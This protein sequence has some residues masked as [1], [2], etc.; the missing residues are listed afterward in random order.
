MQPFSILSLVRRAPHP[1]LVVC[2]LACTTPPAASPARPALSEPAATGSS[3]PTNERPASS[4][5]GDVATAPASGDT[6]PSEPDAPGTP[7]PVPDAGYDRWLDGYPYPFEV[8]RMPLEVQG[9]ALC[10]AYMDALPAQP[11]GHVVLLLHGKNFSG[12]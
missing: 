9:R 12:A 1:L 2:A 11:N 3:T 6:C 10:L 4:A 8:R 5:S 7:L